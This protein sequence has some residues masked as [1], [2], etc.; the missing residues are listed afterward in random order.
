MPLRDFSCGSCAF[1]QERFYH[2]TGDFPV[3]VRCG[4]ALAMLERSNEGQRRQTGAVFPFTTPHIDPKGR[5]MTI[6]SMG[7]LRQ[8]ERNYGVILSVFSNEHNNSVDHIKDP[9]IYRGWNRE[10]KR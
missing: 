10:V 3:C 2:F 8:V 5:P 1:V 4:G 9:P 7:H 6:E